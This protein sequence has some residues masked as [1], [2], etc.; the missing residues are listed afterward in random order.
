[1]SGSGRT[2]SWKLISFVWGPFGF[3]RLWK[4]F[5]LLI[6]FSYIKIIAYSFYFNFPC[7]IHTYSFMLRQLFIR[8]ISSHNTPI[9]IHPHKPV[10]YEYKELLR[11][12]RLLIAAIITSS[13]SSI[14]IISWQDFQDEKYYSALL[15]YYSQSPDA[16]NRYSTYQK[17]EYYPG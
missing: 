13:C 3:C 5:V 6:F 15:F 11:A 14:I 1:M 7:F 16:S 8:N 10:Y 9:I 2:Q 4:H 12:F 17:V